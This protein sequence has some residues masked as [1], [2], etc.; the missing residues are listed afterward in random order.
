MEV[1]DLLHFRSQLLEDLPGIRALQ[2]ERSEI[3]RDV[4][5]LYR[6]PAGEVLQIG[7]VGLGSGEQELVVAVPEDD[8]VL[9]HPTVVV[10]PDRVMRLAR[11]AFS[12]VTSQDACKESLGV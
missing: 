3:V 4:F 8:S 11:T 7:H 1:A 5:D 10:T 9:D 6:H 12:D 2:G